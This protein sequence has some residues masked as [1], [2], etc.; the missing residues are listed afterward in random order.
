MGDQVGRPRE[1]M[2]FPTGHRA[3]LNRFQSFGISYSNLFKA[4][5]N[6]SRK[7]DKYFKE[8]F[9]SFCK[10]GVFDVILRK[11]CKISIVEISTQRWWA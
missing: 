1:R 2:L 7:P 9:R 8:M 3:G 11:F 5:E 10:M 6:N 4:S